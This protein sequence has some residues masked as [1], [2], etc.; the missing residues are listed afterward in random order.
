MNIL[1]VKSAINAASFASLSRNNT[2]LS[3]CGIYSHFTACDPNGAPHLKNDPYYSSIIS[4][5]A[6]Y[7]RA[8]IYPSIMIINLASGLIML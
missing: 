3:C 8:I 1:E 4:P 5:L 6:R 2:D 7:Q